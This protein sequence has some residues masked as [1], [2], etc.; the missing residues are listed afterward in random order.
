[1][2]SS[3]T[4]NPNPKTPSPRRIAANRANG[5]KS[6]GPVTPEGKARSSQNARTHGLASAIVVLSTENWDNYLT[7]RESYIARFRPVDN[8]ELDFVEEMV[9]ARWRLQRAWAVESA[10]MDDEVAG[11]S[12]EIAEKYEQITPDVRTALAFKK[13][14]DKSK[15]PHLLNRY[16][17][18]ASRQFHRALRDLRELRSDCPP[19]PDCPGPNAPSPRP[20]QNT[21]LQN[22]PKPISEH[23]SIQAPTSAVERPHRAAVRRTPPEESRL[24]SDRPV[25]ST[26]MPASSAPSPAHP[27]MSAGA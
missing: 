3:S 9:A 23:P 10:S 5:A 1:M 15:S 14:A 8:V 11:Q 19:L 12:A 4:G 20:A 17:A 13:L 7:L 22:E 18:K 25:L 16:E 24:E 6:R 2:S 26:A 21:I 27:R